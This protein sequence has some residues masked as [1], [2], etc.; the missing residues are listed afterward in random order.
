MQYD[1]WYQTLRGPSVHKH[2]NRSNSSINEEQKEI[3]SLREN[4]SIGLEE[5]KILC[6]M[7]DSYS[8]DDLKLPFNK[9]RI[10]GLEA[11]GDENPDE[12]V[13]ENLDADFDLGG[14]DTN[15]EDFADDTSDFMSDDDS[16][17]KVKDEPLNREESVDNNFDQNKQIR[18]V[19][20]FPNKFKVLR[21]IVANNAEISKNQSH[22]NNKVEETLRNIG[23][24]YEKLLNS[25][26]TY[27]DSIDT[28]VHEDIFADYIQYHTAAKGLKMA[29]D[30]V[31]SF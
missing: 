21:D 4:L 17:E 7:I 11:E 26:D 29:Y 27:I 14:D 20:N 3:R 22:M 28:K 13:D 30:A 15:F 5:D 18:K 1:G 2:T 12:N 25:L 9:R 19:L 6:N 16:K 23:K 10:Y 8:T 31:M 24:R